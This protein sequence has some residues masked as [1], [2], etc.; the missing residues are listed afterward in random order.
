M[1]KLR[2]DYRQICST[3]FGFYEAQERALEVEDY[4]AFMFYQVRIEVLEKVKNMM[5]N[6]LEAMNEV[7]SALLAIEEDCD[8]L[9]CSIKR[10]ELEED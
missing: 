3:L 2:A 7:E 5:G 4:N 10:T 1:D 8:C 6:K 9:G